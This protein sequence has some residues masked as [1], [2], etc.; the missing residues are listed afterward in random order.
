MP[1]FKELEKRNERDPFG[2]L[3][4]LIV[5]ILLTGVEGYSKVGAGKEEDGEMKRSEKKAKV[6]WF[7]EHLL[8]L[9]FS[10]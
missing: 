6:D 2:H 4:D 1:V 7:V 5:H 9:S 8:F 10:K 3:T